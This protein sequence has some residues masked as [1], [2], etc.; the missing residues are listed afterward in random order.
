MS[1]GGELLEERAAITIKVFEGEDII[2][3]EQVWSEER[4]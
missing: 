4:E 1:F 3:C 2:S